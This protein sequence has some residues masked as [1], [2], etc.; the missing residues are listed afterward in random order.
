[1]LLLQKQQCLVLER[2]GFGIFCRNEMSKMQKKNAHN[3]PPPFFVCDDLK[4]RAPTACHFQKK[5]IGI[6]NHPWV[7]Y[8]YIYAQPP[9]NKKL[10]KKSHGDCRISNGFGFFGCVGF[11]FF[12]FSKGPSPKSIQV[13]FVG[14]MILFIL[15]QGSSPNMHK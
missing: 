3:T 12:Y 9:Q 2:T 5:D 15:C 11:V 13:F 4:Q 14:S 1:M 6:S 7:V 8:I 10:K